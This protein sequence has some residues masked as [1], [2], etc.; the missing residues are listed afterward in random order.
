MKNR[1]WSLHKFNLLDVEILG[2]NRKTGFHPNLAKGKIIN[3]LAVL[4]GWKFFDDRTGLWPVAS[5]H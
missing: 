4:L 1:T 5:P 3:S 2:V